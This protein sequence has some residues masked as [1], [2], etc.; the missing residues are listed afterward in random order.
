MCSNYTPARGDAL[1]ELFGYDDLPAA[2]P[3]AYPGYL[4]P[5][6]RAGKP[7]GDLVLPTIALGAFGLIPHWAKDATFGRRTYNA[8]YETVRE[9]PSFRDA[10]RKAQRCI[11]PAASIFEPR[12]LDGKAQ[13]CS[14]H[15][16]DRKAFYLLGLWSAWK[17]P[18]G[19]W[20][21]TFTMLTVNA[22]G[23]PLMGQFHK[24]SD[25]KR[26][27]VTADRPHANFWLHGA[28]EEDLDLLEPLPAD[29]FE[30]EFV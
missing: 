1:S 6:V 17:T 13:R 12:Y 24:P 26:S 5:F 27:V 7:F 16:K 19:S 3:I 23:H 11:I 22:D 18:E 20:L 25:E 4:A 8:R 9:K 28:A 10:W 14:I 2:P 29:E 15:R 30:F 21:P